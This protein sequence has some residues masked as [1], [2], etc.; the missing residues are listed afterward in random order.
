MCQVYAGAKLHTVAAA[1]C[2]R[3]GHLVLRGTFC[4][5]VLPRSP[6]N[7]KMTPDRAQAPLSRS[8]CP[9][10]SGA[11]IISIAFIDRLRATIKGLSLKICFTPGTLLS[12]RK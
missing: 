3:A 2:G 9:V 11:R 12:G 10:S 7:I 4:A 6:G 1:T 8:Y 5:P